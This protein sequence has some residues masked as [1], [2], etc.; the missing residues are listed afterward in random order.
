M[1]LYVALNLVLDIGIKFFIYSPDQD[2]YLNH[3]KLV[4]AAYTAVWPKI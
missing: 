1:T 4:F 2:T 3:L